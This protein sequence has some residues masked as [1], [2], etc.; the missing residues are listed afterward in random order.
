MEHTQLV[1]VWDRCDGFTMDPPLDM[2]PQAPV[3][4]GV[5]MPGLAPKG[6]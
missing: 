3:C 5:H 6:T 1:N 4:G 2:Y